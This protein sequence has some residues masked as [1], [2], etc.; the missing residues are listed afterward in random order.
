MNGTVLHMMR[1]FGGNDDKVSTQAVHGPCPDVIFDCGDELSEGLMFLQ[2]HDAD[3][4]TDQSIAS[5]RDIPAT[6]L[7]L[8]SQST[9][10][11]FC[12]WDLL[13]D[14]Q[15]TNNSLTIWCNA[16]TKTTNWKRKLPGYGWVWYYPD[17]IANILSLS[18]VKQRYRVT[19][20]SA[21]D[22][23]FIV[24]KDDKKIMRFKEA[25][26]RLYYFDTANRG[27]TGNMLIT[28]VENN[29]SRLSAYDFNH[30]E[31]SRSLQRRIGRPS[32]KDFIRYIAKNM[33]P[34]CPITV[35]DIKMPNMCGGR[36]LGA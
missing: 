18:R 5:S 22:N 15:E 28:T 11:V 23:C 13:T 32:T 16:R 2:P 24:H 30:A 34:N 8:D 25:P 20:D 3:S 31:K 7:L 36:T 4:R 1:E 26:R 10:D 19:F 33:I 21:A 9:I 17:D 35:Q 27:K 12:N 6:W 14:I 29:S